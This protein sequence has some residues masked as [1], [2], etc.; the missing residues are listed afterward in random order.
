MLNSDW[1]LARKLEKSNIYMTLRDCKL[2]RGWICNARKLTNSCAHTHMPNRSRYTRKTVK[3]CMKVIELILK[4]DKLHSVCTA[5]LHQLC[6]KLFALNKPERRPYFYLKWSLRTKVFEICICWPYAFPRLSMELAKGIKFHQ[7]VQWH[8]HIAIS[9]MR[10]ALNSGWIF[11]N[12]EV[13]PQ[14]VP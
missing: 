3:D 5:F 13:F 4:I 14:F 9:R 2:F 7:E 8:C 6:I 11:H 12:L 10:N 1:W